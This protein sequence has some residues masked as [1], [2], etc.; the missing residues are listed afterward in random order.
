MLHKLVVRGTSTC[1]ALTVFFLGWGIDSKPFDGLLPSEG[2][3][4]MVWDY[5]SLDF[6]FSLLAPYPRL[7]LA[8]W[9][10]GVWAANQ[11]LG[12]LAFES[13]VAFNGTP[14]PVDNE[15]GIPVAVF[16]ATLANLSEPALL[17]F[18]R[19][20]CGSANLQYFLEHRPNR[21]VDDLRE[22]LAAIGTA[23]SVPPK[24]F[25]WSHALIGGDDRI[26][27][28]AA[29]LRAWE[30]T[31]HTLFPGEPHYSPALLKELYG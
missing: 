13:A 19:R 3:L 1:D 21:S 5:R 20:M 2:D 6:N 30:H 24:P 12:N 17:K 23:C 27:P 15:T 14:T 28:A 8:A 22:E 11:V 10:M 29:Q 25:S 31:P 7:R 16:E 26:F 4:L 9:S 18:Y